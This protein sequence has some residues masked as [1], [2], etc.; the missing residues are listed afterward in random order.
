MAEAAL[1]RVATHVTFDT[2]TTERLVQLGATNVVRA[3]DCLIIGPSRRDPHEHT[4]TREA[5]LS[6]SE[7]HSDTDESGQKWDRLHSSDVRWEPPVVVWVS[8]SLHER[9]N[10]WRTCSWLRHLGIAHH[11]V[12][13]LDFEPVPPS[14]AA[15]QGILARPFTCSESVSDHPDEILLDRLDKTQPWSAERYDRAIR[16]WDSY[17]DENPSLFVESCISGVEGFAELAPLWA[18]LSCFFPRKTAEGGLR[19]SRF[20]KMVFTLLSSEWQTAL[21][22]AVHESETRMR[23]WNLLS[24][25]GDLFLEDR[26][27]QWAMHDSSAF[28]ERAAG[29][30]PPGHPML[31]KVYRLTGRGMQLQDKGLGQLTDAP[32]LPM[33]GTEAY[34]A[35]AP[36]VL[37]EDG[38]LARL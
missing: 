5:W 33:A 9:V 11:D 4:R 37:L 20:D 31:S 38:R 28:V 14:R 19:L 22:L 36:W 12:L 1:L 17:V 2:P 27:D 29:P 26:L 13:V 24:C 25:T 8:A 30:K 16:L 18:L 15:S 7:E 21:A 23:L 10:L 35:S 3:S 6:S 32:S 34:S